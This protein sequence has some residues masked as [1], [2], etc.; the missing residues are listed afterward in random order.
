MKR[1]EIPHAPQASS[2]GDGEVSASCSVAPLWLWH[3]N[4]ANSWYGC[5]FSDSLAGIGK[6]RVLQPLS[7]CQRA[8]IISSALMTPR[9][10][11][12]ERSGSSCMDPTSTKSAD[13]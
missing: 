6:H 9:G 2:D 3:R 13:H 1:A 8:V 10:K 11:R 4:R 12:V 5:F 7:V